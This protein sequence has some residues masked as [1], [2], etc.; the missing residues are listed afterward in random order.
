MK[1]Y[2]NI[3]IKFHYIC[4]YTTPLN[5]AIDKENV[6]IV[7]ELVNCQKL[8]ANVKSILLLIFLYNFKNIFFYSLH[9][10]LIVLM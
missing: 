3:F 1:F 4:F 7:K 2:E 10:I 8:D 5:T 9:S 6:D